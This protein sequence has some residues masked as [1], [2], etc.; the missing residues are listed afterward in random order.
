MKSEIY[1]RDKRIDE[2]IKKLQKKSSGTLQRYENY[3]K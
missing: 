3:L 2:I 1:L